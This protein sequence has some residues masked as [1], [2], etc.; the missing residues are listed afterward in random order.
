[1]RVPVRAALVLA[2]VASVAACGSVA[3]PVVSGPRAHTGGTRLVP[4]R[5]GP[6]AGSHAEAAA[7]ARLMLSRLR[8]PPG[9]R[10]LPPAPGP[11]L[12][13]R[14]DL[15]A[16]AAAS[17][18]LHQL[19]ALRQPMD[20]VA[21][22]VVA[23]APA[24]MT[25][26]STGG[27]L[28]PADRL[29]PVDVTSSEVGYMARSVPAGVYAAQLVLTL[30]QTRSG[31]SVVRADAQVIWF[32]PRTAAEYIGPGRYHV[33]AITVT[34]AGA[35]QHT[36]RKVVTSQAAITR[37]AEAL[38]R[39][40]VQPVLIAN[41]PMIF[42][43]YRLAFAVSRLSRPAVVVSATRNPCEGA[44]I[45]AGGRMQPP[46]EDEGTVVAVADQL[47]GVTPEP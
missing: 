8:L 19:F 37:L 45:R 43:D 1:M 44:Q 23:H 29:R 32:P 3:A 42:A 47:L 7:L 10:R 40:P 9:A 26:H 13:R 27:L 14:P 4:A 22:V 33:L 36:V 21:A 34:V 41:C 24:G 31:G 18:D 5:P 11:P 25:W 38:N 28:G 35:R 15:W 39:S 30:A 6:P 17:L 2:A 16:G 12:V 46:L 20:A